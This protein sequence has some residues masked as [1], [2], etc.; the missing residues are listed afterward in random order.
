MYLKQFVCGCNMNEKLIICI[1]QRKTATF[2]WMQILAW[3]HQCW[4]CICAPE[5]GSNNDIFWI[6]SVPN[7]FYMFEA[8]HIFF[9]S[10]IWHLISL[11]PHLV[12]YTA[13]WPG[14]WHQS[15]IEHR[16]SS[17]ARIASR[18]IT[19][20]PWR[21]GGRSGCNTH[22]KKCVVCDNPAL[23][24]K[25]KSAYDDQK[26]AINKS[27]HLISC[28]FGIAHCIGASHPGID[29]YNTHATTITPLN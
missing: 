28:S 14:K 6:E 7:E 21:K 26:I 10:Q 18:K 17:I 20:S 3:L 2:I 11:I 15:G 22:L 9:L 24:S 27:T 16:R 23:H 29:V 5:V 13:A 4:L 12:S 19:H 1:K 25:F 8:N